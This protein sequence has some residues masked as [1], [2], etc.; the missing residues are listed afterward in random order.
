LLLVGVLLTATLVVL[1]S[2]MLVDLALARL[3][4]RIGAADG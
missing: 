2:N 4:P 3:D 1:L